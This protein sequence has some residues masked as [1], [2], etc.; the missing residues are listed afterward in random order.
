MGR[1]PTKNCCK[2]P[3]HSPP[4]Y[5]TTSPKR[6]LQAMMLL[7]QIPFENVWALTTPQE[8]FGL[9]LVTRCTLLPREEPH[10]WAVVTPLASLPSGHFVSLGDLGSSDIGTKKRSRNEPLSPFQALNSLND[11]RIGLHSPGVSWPYDWRLHCLG[12]IMKGGTS[13]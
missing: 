10:C 11:A 5:P 7:G 2:N 9:V 12:P 13:W 4:V 6:M 3:P 1:R 8:L